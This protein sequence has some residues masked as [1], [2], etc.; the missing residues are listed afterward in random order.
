MEERPAGV[1]IVAAQPIYP[2]PGMRNPPEVVESVNVT[3][4]IERT[5][6]EKIMDNLQGNTV[7]T[8]KQG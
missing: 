6:T 8:E 3:R 5:A 2:S 7:I 1:P 4:P